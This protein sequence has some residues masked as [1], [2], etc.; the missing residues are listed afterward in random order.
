MIKKLLL[1]TFLFCSVL[2]TAQ[3]KIPERP[4]KIPFIIDS[5]Y[6]L[7]IDEQSI[8]NNKL[9]NYC[10]STSTEI[11]VMLIP[12]TNGINIETYA[13]ELGQKWGI[14][15]R[16]KDNGIVMLIAK[17]DRMMSI[18][19]GHGIEPI[20]S[21]KKTKQI[22][23]EII[24]PHFKN[25]DFFLG[26]SEGLNT[27][28]DI[29]KNEFTNEKNTTDLSNFITDINPPAAVQKIANENQ[30]VTEVGEPIGL[31]GALII[32]FIFLSIVAVIIFALI[33]IIRNRKKLF[34]GNYTMGGY[35]VS[36]TVYNHVHVNNNNGDRYRRR[37]TSSFFSGS[38]SSGSSSSSSSSGSSY[39]SGNSGSGG[40]FGGG[41]ASGGW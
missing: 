32:I 36:N 26:I 29:L 37:S 10:L 7:S 17:N 3:L 21:N 34:S 38:S 2:V 6:T 16:G 14:G 41:G 35:G 27:I 33:N 11:L 39:S 5:T 9:K 22:I 15:K 30:E 1:F 8:L 25:G 40:T 4:G 19:N 20:L 18:Q 31:V 23:D 13:K 12:T 24:T 28:F